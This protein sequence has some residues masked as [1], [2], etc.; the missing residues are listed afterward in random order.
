MPKNNAF[1]DGS[2]SWNISFPDG[3]LTAAEI[4]AY[5]PHWL[6][7]VDVINRFVTNG[8]RPIII[9]AMVNEF[10]HQPRGESF[11]PNSVGIMMSYAMRRAGYADWTFGTHELWAHESELA[12]HNLSVKDFRTP[13]VTHPK[14]IHKASRK[15]TK[16]NVEPEPVEFKDLALHVKKHP[17]G[18]DALDLTRCVQYALSHQDE[19]WL[20]PD[21]FQ[22]LLAHLGPA[23]ITHS[24]QDR[25]VFARH[26]T[27]ASPT[28]SR[29]IQDIRKPRT[30]ATPRP[31]ITPQSRIKKASSLD[32]SAT[33]KTMTPQKRGSESMGR[34]Q[35]GN[36]RRSG[37]LVDKAINF[38]EE[39]SDA[40]VSTYYHL[41]LTRN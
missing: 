39:E 16:Y 26:D 25:Q 1:G 11:Q 24:H 8:A 28:K 17:Q 7:S 9:A 4:I 27:F 18:A 22:H 35:L 14:H 5:L 15:K 37:R 38:C 20:F 33:P 29:L 19:D 23:A 6:K 30:K 31:G 3:N 41:L 10:R 40:T 32:H 12:E 21:D 34:V 36:K 13:R 2:P